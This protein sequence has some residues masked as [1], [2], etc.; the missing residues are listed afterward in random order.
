[1]Q[2]LNF[3]VLIFRQ[4][5]KSRRKKKLVK[6]HE[7]LGLRRG[8]GRKLMRVQSTPLRTAGR[9]QRASI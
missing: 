2:N 4:F 6:A 9:L 5:P 1:M 3:H 8:Q 7:G